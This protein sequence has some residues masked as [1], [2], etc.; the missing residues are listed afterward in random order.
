MGMRAVAKEKNGAVVMPMT[1]GHAVCEREFRRVVFFPDALQWA[2]HPAIGV[3]GDGACTGSRMA[4]IIISTFVKGTLQELREAF[5]TL[6]NKP[7]V[8]HFL[9]THEI[10]K[11]A[12]E[13]GF[14]L[15]MAEQAK[16]VNYFP[17]VIALM[18][19][20]QFI[21]A[22]YKDAARSRGMMT[23]KQLAGVERTYE[24]RFGTEQGL[25]ATWQLLCLV[26]Q[27]A[28]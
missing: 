13:V 3:A 19:S 12:A 20:L 5:S 8:S 4:R 11:Y 25:P 17:D 14:T 23:L 28:W 1:L 7:H 27:K 24:K 21:G 22:T 18:R 26:L 2:N 10:L 6:D 15:A 9:E 16:I